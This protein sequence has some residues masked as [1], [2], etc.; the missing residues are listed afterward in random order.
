SQWLRLR[1]RCRPRRR[2][3]RRSIMA[4]ALAN[5]GAGALRAQAG[6]R[7]LQGRRELASTAFLL[8]AE[9][10]FRERLVAG[11]GDALDDVPLRLD[12]AQ[13]LFPEREL[14]LVRRRLVLVA[15]A[16]V[17]RQGLVG[18]A[19]QGVF[20]G[21]LQGGPAQFCAAFV[22]L[23]GDPVER[24]CEARA[25]LRGQQAPVVAVAQHFAHAGG[26]QRHHRQAGG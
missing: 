24:G 5:G 12:A 2:F 4:P 15:Q 19:L 6:R 26:V 7:A 21:G 9:Q 10:A 17:V 3:S 25:F 13:H 16:L 14:L 8:L 1:R 23:P 11:N 20:A 18:A 22:T